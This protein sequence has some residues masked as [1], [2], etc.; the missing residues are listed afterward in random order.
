MPKIE[1]TE[2]AANAI[3]II[4]SLFA[5]GL[6]PRESEPFDSRYYY[7]G[8]FETDHPDDVYDYAQRWERKQWPRQNYFETVLEQLRLCD[9]AKKTMFVH[10]LL[11]A[12]ERIYNEV[13][14]RFAE[15]YMTDERHECIMWILDNKLV[16]KFQ[17][18]LPEEEIHHVEFHYELVKTDSDDDN[19]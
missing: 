1:R 12:M 8:D 11:D 19:E 6:P 4:R 10:N 17:R 13:F 5:P 2:V 15:T 18:E 3:S 14:N 7:E 9:K 16:Q